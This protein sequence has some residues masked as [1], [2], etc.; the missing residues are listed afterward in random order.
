M[1]TL[2]TEKPIP[3]D[4]YANQDTVT[5]F[6]TIDIPEKW[7]IGARARGSRDQAVATV[8]GEP[9]ERYAIR[10]RDLAGYDLD[11]EGG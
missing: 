4:V 9:L 11:Y 10:Y 2:P 1:N 8:L 6:W 5:D 3:L 7:I